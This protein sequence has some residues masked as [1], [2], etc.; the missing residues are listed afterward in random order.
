MIEISELHRLFDYNTE[1]GVLTRRV[2]TNNK[3]PVGAVVGSIKKSCKTSYWR[4]W[5]GKQNTYVHRVIWAMVYGDWPKGQIDHIDG[6]GLNNRI[7]N[8]RDVTHSE[9]QRNKRLQSRNKSGHSGV[10]WYKPTQKWQAFI[11]V[12][13]KQKHLGHFGTV[14]EAAAARVAAEAIYW[15]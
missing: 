1:T 6:N 5:F 13:G 11:S 2:K 12:D 10:T 4:C 9:N 8:L 3:C 7:Q 14:E 15:T